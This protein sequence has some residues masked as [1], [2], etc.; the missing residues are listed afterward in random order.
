M[1]LYLTVF[2]RMHTIDV[3]KDYKRHKAYRIDNTTHDESYKAIKEILG[4]EIT[5]KSTRMQKYKK[6][7]EYA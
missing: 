7:N 3:Y 1:E 6:L 2:A 4:L 5:K